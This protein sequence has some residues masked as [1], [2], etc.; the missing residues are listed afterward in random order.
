MSQ[1][2]SIQTFRSKLKALKSI[3]L[4]FVIVISQTAFA[5]DLKPVTY[6]INPQFIKQQLF[7]SNT[8]VLLALNRVQ[9]AKEQVNISRGNLLPSINLG[10]LLSGNPSFLLSSITVLLPFLLPS[11]WMILKQSREQLAAEA[12]AYYISQL[13]AY[14]S[15]LSLYQTYLSDRQVRYVLQEQLY[16]TQLIEEEARKNYESGRSELSELLQA[17]AQTQTQLLQVSQMTVLLEKEGSAMREMLALPLNAEMIFED[18]RPEMQD[19][20]NQ[21][22]I[23]LSSKFSAVSPEK[24][25][26]KHLVEAARLEKWARTFSFIS[27]ASMSSASRGES[28]ASFDN[29]TRAGSVGIGFGYFPQLELSNLNIQAMELRFKEV[30]LENSR[31]AED[32]ATLITEGQKQ[33]EYAIIAENKMADV[34]ETEKIKFESGTID[35]LRLFQIKNAVLGARISSIKAQLQLDQT[36]HTLQRALINGNFQRIENC[37]KRIKSVKIPRLWDR[38]RNRGNSPKTIEAVCSAG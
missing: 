15:A 3:S 38:V 2:Q 12:Q 24:K 4:A 21:S 10:F 6:T 28:N 7:D 31:I 32:I 35:I 27:G 11:N 5:A 33:L 37:D 8:N 23:E 14:A 22:P 13:N 25:Q 17:Q 9:K 1:S 36:R 16:N 20:E 26:I 34:F 30:E 19:D 18:T 29:M